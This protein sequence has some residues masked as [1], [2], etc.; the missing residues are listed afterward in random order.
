MADMEGAIGGEVHQ[1]ADISVS[2]IFYF[3][4]YFNL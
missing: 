3:G 2:L 4:I 1:D